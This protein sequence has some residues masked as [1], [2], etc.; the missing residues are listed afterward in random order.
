MGALPKPMLMPTLTAARFTNTIS[1]GA[2]DISVSNDLEMWRNSSGFSH[3]GP[4]T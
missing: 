1:R 2:G 4:S 3:F